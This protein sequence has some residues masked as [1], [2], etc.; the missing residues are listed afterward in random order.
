MHD[1]LSEIDGRFPIRNSVEQKESF[2][3]YALS[4]AAGHGLRRAVRE[5]NDGHVNLVFSDP[6]TAR[7]IFTAHYDTPRRSLLPN[8]MLVTNPVLYWLYQ[9]GLVLLLLIPAVGAAFG[10]KALFRLDPSELSARMLMLGA[11]LVVYFALFA[12]LLRGPANRRNRNDNTSGT[13][14]V[15]ELMRTLG[16]R[17]DVAFLLFDD[18]EKGKKGSKAYAAAHPAIRQDTLVVN[19]D[20]VGNGETFI[21]CASGKAGASPLYTELQAAV[22]ESGLN[23]RFYPTSRAQMN[24]DHK[25]FRLGV[26]VCACRY[27]P[28]VGYYTGRIHTVRDTLAEP[29]NVQRLA[30]A[31]A[32][33]AERISEGAER[34]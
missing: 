22:R 23:A 20:C 24:S 34:P 7:V 31:L 1:Y 10:A 3:A 29:E 25:N 18:E 26:G 21:F 8:L 2:R 4:E 32:A 30:A 16:E 14:A 12:L 27:Q 17:P 6:A 5:E 33:F 15:M 28:L 9:I 11:Y 19:L 13:A